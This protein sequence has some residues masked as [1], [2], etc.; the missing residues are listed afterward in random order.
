MVLYKNE[1]NMKIDKM[2][3]KLSILFSNSETSWNIG[4][5]EKLLERLHEK[6]KK[7]AKAKNFTK[8]L[9]QIYKSCGSLC[10]SVEEL[11]EIIDHRRETRST[12]TDFEK[13]VDLLCTYPQSEQN[14]QTTFIPAK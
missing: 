7:S 6:L 4:W 9:L 10:T 5:Q 3:Q 13:R 11:Y 12:G 8:T 1:T 2:S 14:C